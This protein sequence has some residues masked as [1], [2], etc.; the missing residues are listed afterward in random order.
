MAGMADKS[1]GIAATDVMLTIGGR[2]MSLAEV[3]QGAQ[4]RVHAFAGMTTPARM[5]FEA[6]SEHD[7]ESLRLLWWMCSP[8]WLQAREILSIVASALFGWLP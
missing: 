3:Q 6:T 1:R 5:T 7:F 2:R 8:K 4:G